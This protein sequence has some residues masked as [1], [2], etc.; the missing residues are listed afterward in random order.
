[1]EN[2]EKL[3]ECICCGGKHL[4]LVL[5]MGNQP[6]ANN[7][8]KTK[9]N[10]LSYPIGINRCQ[11]CNH[12]QL[13]HSVDSSLLFTE[14]SYHSGISETFKNYCSW[15]CDFVLES[16]KHIEN[17]SI[18]DI[19]CN[20]GT[21]LDYFKE[22]GFLTVGVDPATNIFEKSSKN[23]RIYCNFFDKSVV[24]SIIQDYKKPFS[25]IISQNC[26]AHN[27]NPFEMLTNIKELMVDDTKILIQTS[28]ADMILNGQ[29]D[30]IY[31]EH[32][33]FF[34]ISSMNAL[35]KRAG[36]FLTDV[37]KTSIHGVSYIFVIEKI[38]SRPE[39]IKNLLELEQSYYNDK[40]YCNFVDKVY[41]TISNT[42][43]CLNK[44]KKKNYII[45][46]YGAAAKG[47]V[48]LNFSDI[49]LEF[50]IDDTPEKQDKY[51]PG[52]N[53]P[54]LNSDKL[55]EEQGNIAF[56]ILPWNFYDEIVNRIKKIRNNNNDVF[57]RYY[58]DFNLEINSL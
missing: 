35:C 46:G 15:F 52:K 45:A 50:I 55:K 53:I 8:K 7:Y 56:L 37:I 17:K 26:F 54:I 1:M 51:S 9:E 2:V 6:L 13:T 5:E 58:P 21:Q 32:V 28:Q 39:H 22:Q 34:N 20:D 23:H 12:I 18:L 33:S 42:K 24:G 40:V 30:T 16:F 19:G 48:F 29:F 11:T 36:L 31:H 47:N 43:K 3:T 57:I 44:Y 49:N 25:L 27:N 4:S 14:Y 10:E 41:K 38:D